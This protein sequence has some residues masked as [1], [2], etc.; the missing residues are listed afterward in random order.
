M[1]SGSTWTC[2]ECGRHFAK[3][4]QWHSCEVRGIDDHFRG[5]GAETRSLFDTLV[6][7]LKETGPLRIDAVRTSINLISRHHFGGVRVRAGYLRVGFLATE[8]ILSPRIVHTEVIGTNC[9][10]HTVLIRTTADIDRELLGWLSRARA[11]RS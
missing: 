9:I 11:L 7:R 4:K 1:R 5:K 10:G 6:R 3:T 8:R 2:P